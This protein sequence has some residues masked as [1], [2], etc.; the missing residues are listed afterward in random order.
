MVSTLLVHSAACAVG[1]VMPH[2]E[3]LLALLLQLP[4]PPLGTAPPPPPLLLLLLLLGYI[5]DMSFCAL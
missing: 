2:L 4:L 3:S 5:Q 1:T